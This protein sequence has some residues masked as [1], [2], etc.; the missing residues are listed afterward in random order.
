MC[1]NFLQYPC[2]SGCNLLVVILVNASFTEAMALV[3]PLGIPIGDL[4]V[5][6]DTLDLGFVMESRSLDDTL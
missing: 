2:I 3:E 6:E 5:E 1:N 4:D